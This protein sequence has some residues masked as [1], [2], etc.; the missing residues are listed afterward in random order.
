[1]HLFDL[2]CLD[3]DGDYP[4]DDEFP[5]TSAALEFPSG[6]I[7]W[8]GVLRPAR[9]IEGY[10]RGIFPWYSQGEPVLWW[11]PSPRCV[12]HL[13]DVY[14]STRTRRRLRQG[15]FEITADTAFTEVIEGCAAPAPGRRSTWINA[16]M[17]EAYLQLF[18]MGVAHSVEAWQAGEL[19][20]GVYG[21]AIGHMFF[22]ES[23]FSRKTDASKVALITLCRQLHDWAFGPVDCQVGNPHLGRM[24]A[25]EI[26][27]A[28]FEAL[29]EEYTGRP[30]AD[31]PWRDSFRSDWEWSL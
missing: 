25:A 24:G 1:M 18:E 12:L 21:L 29:L 13:R 8:G 6:L 7:A 22:G 20:G 23:M 26:D 28:E 17:R 2:P 31:G 9:L 27:R 4:G 5:P 15:A 14:V 19:A 30:R 10:R 11:T 16:D 3:G